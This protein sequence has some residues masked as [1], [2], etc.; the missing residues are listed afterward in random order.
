MVD[1]LSKIS[2]NLFNEYLKM[3]LIL[4]YQIPSN[5]LTRIYSVHNIL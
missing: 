4:V 3:L 2:V 1:Y 5:T